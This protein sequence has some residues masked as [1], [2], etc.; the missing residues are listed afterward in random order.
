[1][2]SY[3]MS[4]CP[5]VHVS[6]LTKMKHGN[7]MTIFLNCIILA[8]CLSIGMCQTMNECPSNLPKDSHLKVFGGA[9]YQFPLSYSRTHS[10]AKQNCESQGGTLAL[11]KTQDVQNFLF[12]T[13][14]NDFRDYFDKV[15]IGLS[16]M[17]K[18]KEFKWDD[19]A[20]LT[21]SNWGHLS[22][23]DIDDCVLMDLRNDGKWTEYACDQ[24]PFLIFFTQN[25]KHPYICQYSIAANS[26]AQSTVTATA[27]A[28]T[29]IPDSIA[30][31]ISTSDVTTTLDTVSGITD[32]TVLIISNSC[33]AFSCDLD[34]GM[35]GFQKNET[36]SCSLCQCAV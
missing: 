2:L 27:L 22:T 20:P 8:A 30:S 1:M 4:M 9:C 6:R 10:E 15:W 13:L 16:D 19:G 29:T 35:N 28:R 33:P 36:S 18:E 32:T 26:N 31:G 21:Y 5:S 23:H 25:E 7:T 12:T 14:T 24:S 17:D 11:V 3:L 34:C